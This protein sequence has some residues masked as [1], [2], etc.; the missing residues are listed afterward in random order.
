ML[1]KMSSKFSTLF[2][3]FICGNLLSFAQDSEPSSDLTAESQAAESFS[4]E[5]IETINL[6]TG[7]HKPIID[8]EIDEGFW[9]LAEPLSVE[10]ELYPERFSKALVETKAYLAVT[11]THLY[12]AFYA[13][14]KS[15]V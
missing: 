10:Y 11:E 2:I 9:F 8:G 3:L 13:Y 6:Y 14:G 7:F 4:I 15:V 12:V 5:D 1:K